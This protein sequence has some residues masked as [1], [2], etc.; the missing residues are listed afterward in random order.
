MNTGAS[1]SGKVELQSVTFVAVSEQTS[2]LWGAVMVGFVGSLPFMAV[3]ALLATL[4]RP[5]L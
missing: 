4:L 2:A 1:F 5:V 3:I